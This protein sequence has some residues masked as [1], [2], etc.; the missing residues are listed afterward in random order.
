M[1]VLHVLG[2]CTEDLVNPALTARAFHRPLA[3]DQGMRVSLELEPDDPLA[4][5]KVTRLPHRNRIPEAPMGAGFA[6]DLGRR[7]C[8]H[9]SGLS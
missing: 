6:S 2:G 8:L 1:C 3:D 9:R 4:D 7:P 5:V